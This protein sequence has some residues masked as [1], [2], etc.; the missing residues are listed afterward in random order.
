MT[1]VVGI[2]WRRPC[3][4]QSRIVMKKTNHANKLLLILMRFFWWTLVKWND[5]S[6]IAEYFYFQHNIKLNFNI[7][8]LEYLLNLIFKK[9]KKLFIPYLSTKLYKVL[10]VCNLHNKSSRI[11]DRL[12][13]VGCILIMAP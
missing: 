9:L 8:I 7:K 1:S 6:P 11:Q 13:I 5:H 4:L 3:C 12:A 2:K 10:P